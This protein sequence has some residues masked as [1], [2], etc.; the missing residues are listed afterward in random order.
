MVKQTL[1]YATFKGEDSFTVSE[2]EMKVFIAILIVSGIV[3]VSSRR[4]FWKNSKITRNDAVYNAMRRNRF[5][6]L[7]QFL[8]FADNTC[9]DPTYDYAKLR[10]L[11]NIL[12]NRFFSN[13]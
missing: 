13:F 9:L 4:L 1:L 2:E 3:P 6:K 10:P 11:S 8:H 5:E 7:I 12:Q